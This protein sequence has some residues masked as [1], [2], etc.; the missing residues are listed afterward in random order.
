MPLP[1]GPPVPV[2]SNIDSLKLAS[3]DWWR[4]KNKSG[5]WKTKLHKPLLRS[6][7]Q[8]KVIWYSNP[9]FWINPDSDMDVCRI[10]PK[11]LWIYYLVGVSHFAKYCENWPVTVLWEMLKINLLFHNGEAF[12]KVIWNQYP[13]PN[14]NQKLLLPI[15][16]PNW[17]TD[18]LTNRPDR[19]T[20]ALAK[21]IKI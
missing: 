8:P 18:W 17:Q 14:L 9:D 16:R 5:K 20:S 19:I 13:G 1:S 4:H 10:A 7:S 21:V 11:M 3:L 12:G 6:N 2:C 15:S